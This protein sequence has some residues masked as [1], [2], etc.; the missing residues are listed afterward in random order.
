MDEVRIDPLLALRVPANLAVRR[1]MLPFVQWRGK[2]YVACVD[3]RDATSLGAVQRAFELPIE[4]VL[5]ESESLRR[6]LARIYGSLKP[7]AGGT[8]A[9]GKPTGRASE[10]EV[11]DGAGLSDELLYSAI[12]RQASDIHIDPGPETLRIRFRVDGGLEEI[13]RLPMTVAGARR[14]G[15]AQDRRPV[16]DTGVRRSG[17]PG[18]SQGSGPIGAEPGHHGRGEAPGL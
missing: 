5:A 17:D 6:A 3:L 18:V 4:P 14:R 15:L 13:Q 1:E 12:L 2:V 16:E 7:G 8:A 9:I 11:I 10:A